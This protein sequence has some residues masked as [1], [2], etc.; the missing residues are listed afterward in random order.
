MGYD[1][2]INY[3]VNVDDTNFQSKLTQMRASMDTTMGGG[4]GGGFSQNMMYGAMGMFG[5]GGGGVSDFG[6]QIR[7]VSFTPPAIALSPHFGMYQVNQTLMQAGLASMGGPVG[8]GVSGIMTNYRQGGFS[9]IMSGRG[10][11]PENLTTAEYLAM[12]ARG[13]GDRLGDAAAISTLTAGSTIAQMGVGA[14]GWAAGSAAFGGG[15]IMGTI[16][17]LAGASLATLPITATVGAITDM[18][19][20]NRQ[21]QAA[22]AA[23]SFRFFTG[24]GRDV[25]QLTGRGMSRRARADVATSI[26]GMELSDLRYGMDEYKQVLEGGMQMDLFSGTKDVGDF[27]TKFKGLVDTLKTVTSTLHTSLKE[28]LEVVRGF[29]DMGVTDPS[30]VTRLVMSSEMQGR[31]SGRTGQEMLSIGQA[32]AEMFRGTGINME[33][34]FELNQLNTTTVRNLLNQGL[35]TR[36]TIG[37]AGG[38]NALAQQ[39]TA[40]ALSAMQTSH[41]RAAMMANFDPTTGT[42][43]PNMVTN[44]GGKDLMSQIAGAAGMGPAG[45]LKFQAHQEELISGMTP[46][47][48]QL[49]T[50]AMGAGGARA[51]MRQVPGL[52]FEDSFRVWQQ[53]QGMSKPQIDTQLAMLHQDPEKMRENQEQAVETM[54]NQAGLED[55]RNRFSIGKRVSNALRDNVVVRGT[56]QFLTEMSTDVGDW[57][58]RTTR[59]VGGQAVLDPTMGGKAVSAAARR[60]VAAGGGRTGTVTDSTA[61]GGIAGLLGYA[62]SG[63]ELGKEILESGAYDPTG[64]GFEHERGSGGVYKYK[65]SV[66]G[67][68]ADEAELAAT[69]KR[70]GE[71]YTVVG[72]DAQHR[73]IAINTAEMKKMGQHSRNL[74]SNKEAQDKVAKEE[75]DD[76]KAGAIFKLGES[77]SDDLGAAFAAITGHKNTL[78]DLESTLV[79]DEGFKKSYGRSRSEVI[80]ETEKYITK[81]GSDKM[82]KRLKQ[83]QGT[84]KLADTAARS[85][86]EAQQIVEKDKSK[87]LNRVSN[88]VVTDEQGNKT[89]IHTLLE[90]NTAATM[91]LFDVDLDREKKILALS[92]PVD[93]GGLG[94]PAKEVARTVDRTMFEMS[95]TSEAAKEARS[96][97]KGMVHEMGVNIEAF[98]DTAGAVG[99][100][101]GATG[102]GDL[103]KETVKVLEAQSSQLLANYKQLIS[104]QE[105]LNH[106]QKGGH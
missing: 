8:A 74:Q 18:M 38:E 83:E 17:G 104:L 36:E 64:K 88:D 84:H 77:G 54:R 32:G 105:K 79:T 96:K 82:Q 41:G 44:M 14:A 27:K 55:L 37:Q 66:A 34:G 10:A 4:A 94:L 22:L 72:H 21:N 20:D 103:S 35:L 2:T 26:Q 40:G 39:M 68:F 46:E 48:M 24:A 33:R 62:Q 53:R 63:E 45:L 6:S 49:T 95:G 30:E 90:K 69:A 47:Q 23:G 80:A 51:L 89:N 59:S 1:Q 58:E 81:Y 13:F 76:V 106:L 65:G 92:R 100:G 56:S 43:N 97:V 16:G 42:M 61:A 9:G 15:A 98:K 75:V 11:V 91:T 71:D 50:I 93:Q 67:V 102:I 3:R 70:R 60:A 87:L 29:R 5:G 73:V 57:V 31:M 85:A 19:A 7:P 99:A 101:A 78:Q 12:S 25:D 28:G 52:G 86:E